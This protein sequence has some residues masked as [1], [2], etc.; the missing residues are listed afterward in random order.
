MHGPNLCQRLPSSLIDICKSNLN[1]VWKEL[2]INQS[3]VIF[4]SPYFRISLHAVIWGKNLYNVYGQFL[5]KALVIQIKLHRIDDRLIIDMKEGEGHMKLLP[6]LYLRWY[7]VSY[8]QAPLKTFPEQTYEILWMRKLF[9]D[10]AKLL[11]FKVLYYILVCEYCQLYYDV[12]CWRILPLSPDV[13]SFI[14]RFVSSRN[15]RTQNHVVIKVDLFL[16]LRNILQGYLDC[17]IVYCYVLR[18][19]FT[20][21]FFV[22]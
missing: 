20:Y 13:V 16:F 4:Y 22:H 15:L 21:P 1:I 9:K 6:K 5:A 18:I 2:W 11:K 10:Q 7:F 12:S 17:T 8:P 3:L 14:Q 19:Q